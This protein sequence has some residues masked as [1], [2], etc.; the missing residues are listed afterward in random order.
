MGSVEHICKID[1]QLKDTHIPLFPRGASASVT[2][3]TYVSKR[4]SAH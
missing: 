1:Q 2:A 3:G 4:P